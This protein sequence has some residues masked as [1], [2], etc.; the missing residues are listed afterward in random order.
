MSKKH[1]RSHNI[2]KNK[3][4]AP[5]V[6]CKNTPTTLIR[7]A[8]RR[9]LGRN[10]WRRR[11]RSNGGSALPSWRGSRAGVTLWQILGSGET[12]RNCG[13][14]KVSPTR[15]VGCIPNPENHGKNY[16]SLNWLGGFQPSMVSSEFFGGSSKSLRTQKLPLNLL[17]KPNIF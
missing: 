14:V 12:R 17:M 11:R 9:R 5:C 15:W 16:R 6:P 13:K 3:N 7:A 1:G 10:P 4:P 2:L 8:C